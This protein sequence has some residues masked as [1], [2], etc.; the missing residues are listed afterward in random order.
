[1]SDADPSSAEGWKG[2]ASLE[3]AREL[4]QAVTG[5]Y[6]RINQQR[7]FMRKREES[8]RVRELFSGKPTTVA[9]DRDRVVA[10]LANKAANTHRSI[11]VLCDGSLAD[12]AYALC[13]VLMENAV[14]LSWITAGPWI[15]RVDTFGLFYAAAKRRLVQVITD[16]HARTPF[17]AEAEEIWR[18]MSAESLIAEKLFANHHLDWA[19]FPDPQKPGKVRI[20]KLKEMLAEI[21][22]AH[23]GTT[24]HHAYAFAYFDSSHF[25]HS[26]VFG[27][28]NADADMAREHT[29]CIAERPRTEV[30][31]L[32]L[33]VSSLW[34][35]T[36]VNGLGEFLRAGIDDEI[37]ALG[38]RLKAYGSELVQK[39]GFLAEA[40][41]PERADQISNV[42]TVGADR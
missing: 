26:T 29:F 41:D 31:R 40:Q 24:G 18:T 7:F 23:V 32:A 10:A 22:A 4:H 11:R 37:E 25:V 33:I 13:R 9:I 1:M 34:M 42:I 5:L 8:P 36:A 27:I 17:A 20:V 28:R 21:D 19:R 16:H 39:A 2:G 6:E 12:D 38:K 30:A 3:L 15:E 14:I 35:L